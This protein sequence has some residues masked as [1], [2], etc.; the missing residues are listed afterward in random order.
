MMFSNLIAFRFPVRYASDFL[1]GIEERLASGRLKPIGPMEAQTCG[2]VSPFSEASEVLSAQHNGLVWFALGV[3]EKVLPR[4]ALAREI[5]RRM[6]KLDESVKASPR[7]RKQVA[8]E[9]VDEMLPK[10][11][12]KY[13]R[14]H[15]FVDPQ[16]GT[17]VVDATS[18]KSAERVVTAL[19]TALGSFP[20]MPLNPERQVA[21]ILTSWL[22]GEEMPEDIYLGSSVEM[23]DP[24]DS[25]AVVRISG[26]DLSGQEI[27]S[28]LDAGK[29]CVKLAVYERE[30]GEF[31]LTEELH[32]KQIRIHDIRLEQGAEEMGETE[33]ANEVAVAHF[34]LASDV[35]NRLLERVFDVFAVTPAEPLFQLQMEIVQ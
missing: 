20:A 35:A 12:T 26:Q 5:E 18:Q 23:R 15:C 9:V 3:E 1:E 2:F 28:H 33:S 17:L 19:R 24:A 7:A 11:F 21:S 13:A 31:V 30:V 14:M 29:R 25:G 10:A 4:Q 8:R 27:A 32:I 34:I 16:T 6:A 22:A